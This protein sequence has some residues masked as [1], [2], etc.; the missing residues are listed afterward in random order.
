MFTLYVEYCIT[1]SF[2][3]VELPTAENMFANLYVDN[4]VSGCLS[5][6]EA[7]SY[8]NKAQSIMNDDHLSL[9]TWASNSPRLMDQAKVADNNNPVNVLVLQWNT[10]TDTLSLRSKSSIPS[11]TSLI[12]KREVLKE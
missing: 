8:Y 2:S 7:S 10:Q 1:L 12:T 4:I 6:L 5:E 3:S 11:I 9:R